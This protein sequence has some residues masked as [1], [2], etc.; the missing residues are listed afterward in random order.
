MHVVNAHLTRETSERKFELAGCRERGLPRLKGSPLTTLCLGNSLHCRPGRGVYIGGSSCFAH[1]FFFFF[2]LYVVVVNA[3]LAKA[4]YGSRYA[5]ANRRSK[6]A[7]ERRSGGRLSAN[8][9]PFIHL[10]FIPALVRIFAKGGCSRSRYLAHPRRFLR[11]R[12]NR[13]ALN[14]TAYGFSRYFGLVAAFGFSGFGFARFSMTMAR[15]KADSPVR[16]SLSR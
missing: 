16:A 1:T 5:Y 10:F 9:P 2:I 13:P 14:A 8:M 4:L 11:R 12:G 6:E 15:R 3:S 7:L